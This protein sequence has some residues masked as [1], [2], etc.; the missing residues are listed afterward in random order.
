MANIQNNNNKED[1]M[2]NEENDLE[3]ASL[4]APSNVDVDNNSVK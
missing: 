1:V 4:D 3:C 2:S